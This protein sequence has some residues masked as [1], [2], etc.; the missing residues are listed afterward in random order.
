VPPAAAPAMVAVVFGGLVCGLGGREEDRGGVLRVVWMC[1]MPLERVSVTTC[2]TTAGGG[3]GALLDRG[4]SWCE[5]EI[6]AMASEA[7][8]GAA[9]ECSSS[10]DD[11]D[12]ECEVVIGIA[13]DTGIVNAMSD[14]MLVFVLLSL[15][16]GLVTYLPKSPSRLVIVTGYLGFKQLLLRISI[17]SAHRSD[18][19]RTEESH[20]E[21]IHTISI[22]IALT[23]LHQTRRE[24]HQV[25]P[26][27]VRPT[28]T[29]NAL[30]IISALAIIRIEIA[31]ETSVLIS[32][33]VLRQ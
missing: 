8:A 13:T 31:L 6:D 18:Q 7:V 21:E 30:K 20:V 29:A 5:V 2:V 9:S 27:P 11:A 14:C 4:G 22:L 19:S 32:V 23:T 15:V 12:G 3:E 10:E 17:N 33:S 1:V 28:N 16:A 26:H 24:G 25:I